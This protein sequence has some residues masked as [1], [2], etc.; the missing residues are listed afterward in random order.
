M[1]PVGAGEPG[2][3]AGAG[4][5]EAVVD[6]SVVMPAQQD[7]VLD[8]GVSAVAPVDDVVGVTPAGRAATA[9][10]AAVPIPDDDR[11]AHRVRHRA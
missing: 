6:Q 10:E 9:W 2:V 8:I 5:S 11:P 1:D 4:Q 3:G 7:E